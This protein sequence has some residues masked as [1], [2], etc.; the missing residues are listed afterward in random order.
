MEAERNH[1][2]KGEPALI[3]AKETGG[4]SDIF[5]E[6]RPKHQPVDKLS[7]LLLRGAARVIPFAPPMG[8]EH[9]RCADRLAQG[10]ALGVR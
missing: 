9:Q 8:Q 3:H 10:N 6:S 7:A 5:T 4:I 1:R 2:E